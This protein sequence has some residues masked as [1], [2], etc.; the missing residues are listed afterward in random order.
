[1][2]FAKLKTSFITGAVELEFRQT[3]KTFTMKVHLPG[4][5][6]GDLMIP[7]EKGKKKLYINGQL[8]QNLAKKGYF[9][10]KDFP[11]GKTFFEVK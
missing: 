5:V 2:K 9:H 11:A 3:E 4:G 6:K 10:L 7:A 8:V 1:M